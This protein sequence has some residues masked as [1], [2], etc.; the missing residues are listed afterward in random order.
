MRD[1]E[2]LNHETSGGQKPVED[3]NQKWTETV[4]RIQLQQVL[5]LEQPIT[6]TR[7]RSR[8]PCR[9]LYSKSPSNEAMNHKIQDKMP[10]YL[11]YGILL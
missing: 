9:L 11:W 4:Q 7:N 5:F 8:E 6:I 2:T 10:E 1:D 3:R